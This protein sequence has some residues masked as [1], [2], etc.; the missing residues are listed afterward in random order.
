[1]NS[2]KIL[3]AGETGWG[4]LIEHDAGYISPND[5]R[6]KPFINEVNK[7]ASGKG[8][9][10]EPLCLYVVL[11]KYGVLNNNGRIYP[12]HILVRENENYQK[13]IQENRAIGECEH[14]DT[15]IINTKE[16]SH[17]ILETWWEGKTLLGKMEIIMSPGYINKGI[18]SCRGDLVANL[19]RKNVRVGVSSRGVGS[20]QKIDGKHV[21]QD[22]FELICWDVV[23]APSTPG[24]WIFN[25]K[26][27]MRPF[28]EGKIYDKN[29]VLS[30]AIK[31][32]LI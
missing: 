25:N 10:A 7:L 31:K 27:D 26:E 5:E 12:Q 32:F 30:E 19:L 22:D 15:S 1:M 3:K 21:V 14:P 18:I 9:I 23:T 24:S 8:V 2:P 20:L 4:M 16:V 11:Q 6:N 13:V 28:T 17:R 29:K